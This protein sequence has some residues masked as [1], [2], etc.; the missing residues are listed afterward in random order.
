M[1]LLFLSARYF[2]MCRSLLRVKVFPRDWGGAR[3]SLCSYY[4]LSC[5]T[6]GS[7]TPSPSSCCQSTS[8]CCVLLWWLAPPPRSAHLCCWP[9]ANLCS[10]R[11]LY[12]KAPCS[13]LTSAMVTS[14]ARLMIFTCRKQCRENRICTAPAALP[15]ELQE[16][17]V[18]YETVCAPLDCL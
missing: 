4:H 3:S 6:Y 2:Q 18:L 17:I 9:H 12:Q 16:A 13:C 1:L 14:T 11:W 10:P 7:D 5:L 15:Q 8:C